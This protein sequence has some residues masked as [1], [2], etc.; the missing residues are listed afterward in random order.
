MEPKIPSALRRTAERKNLGG[1]LAIHRPAVRNVGKYAVGCV[2]SW[3]AVGAVI[4]SWA[5]GGVFLWNGGQ[6]SPAFVFV[7]MLLIAVAV[8]YLLAAAVRER[9]AAPS[10]YVFVDGLV[11]SGADGEA[12]SARWDALSCIEVV[13]QRAP[14]Y[15][16]GTKVVRRAYI[17]HGQ[18]GT[19]WPVHHEFRNSADFVALVNAALVDFPAEPCHG[20]SAEAGGAGGDEPPQCRHSR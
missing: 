5:N 20:T 17:L 11:V 14:D 18:D 10:A 4:S 13:E 16:R 12:L 7:L 6:V 3:A 2:V 1:L 19:A 9:R 8:S 15:V